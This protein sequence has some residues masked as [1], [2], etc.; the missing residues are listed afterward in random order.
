MLKISEPPLLIVEQIFDVLKEV[1]LPFY[2]VKTFNVLL[3]FIKN[4]GENIDYITID[5]SKINKDYSNIA[6]FKKIL[7]I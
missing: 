1:E 7:I 4:Y 5:N 6:E 2:I 3:A